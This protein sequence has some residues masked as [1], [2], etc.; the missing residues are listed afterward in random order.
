MTVSAFSTLGLSEPLLRVLETENYTQPTP[1]QAQTIPLILSGRDLLG[2]AQTGT[3]KTAAFGLPMLQRL[4]ADRKP[5]EPKSVRALILAPTRELAV[6]IGES[7]KTYGK[8]YG[9]KQAVDL[10]RRRPASADPD[11]ARAAST[12]SSPRRAA[13]STS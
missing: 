4:A 9:C 5:L 12:S 1:I 13:C 11:D 2:I 6:Q 3:G 10:R 7:L 8:P